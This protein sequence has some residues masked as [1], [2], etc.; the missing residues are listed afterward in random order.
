MTNAVPSPKENMGQPIPRVDGR[1]KVTGAARYPS[2]V[3]I[4]NPAYAY[5][6]TSAIARGKVSK[7]DIERAKD[8]SG[9]LDVLTWQT[10]Q[11]QLKPGKYWK[12]GGTAA[13]TIQPLQSDQV[14][15]GTA[16][17]TNPRYRAD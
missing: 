2:D 14:R 12:K 7:I 8:V 15:H 10:L 1:D 6:V 4:S 5:L 9:I 11:G 13:T 3:P 16:F 17:P